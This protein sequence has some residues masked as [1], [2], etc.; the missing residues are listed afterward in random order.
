MMRK[1]LAALTAVMLVLPPAN[2]FA[3]ANGTMNLKIGQ[4]T[5]SSGAYVNDGVLYLELE[6]VCRALSY[7]VSNAGSDSDIRLTGPSDVIQIDPADNQVVQNGHTIGVAGLSQEDLLGGGCLRLSGTLYMRAD[8]L[9]QLLGLDVQ[10][11]E[12]AKTVTVL[13]II[14]NILSVQTR[15]SDLS[16][17]LLSATIQYPVLSGPWSGQ[18][19][20]AINTALKQA[21]DAALSQGRQNAQ[22]MQQTASLRKAS[23]LEDDGSLQC[24]AYFDYE[25]KYN[26]NGLFSIVLSNYQ[27]EGGA[28]GGTI[29]TA[30][31]FDLNTGKQLSLGSL[32]KNGSGYQ[33]EFDAKIRSGIDERE[34]SGALVEI[35]NSPFKTLGSNPD[36]YLSDA[37][38]AFYF[39]QYQYF[40]Y[41]AGIQEFT[42]PY[43]SISSMLNP[44]YHFLYEKLNRAA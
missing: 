6:P 10:T 15:R 25:V 35:A 41:A 44:S 1:L 22:E 11:D 20:N 8:L 14:Q 4:S 19:L 13:R 30:Y 43:G 34:K 24:A 26:Q 42:I 21:A 37:G 7:Q 3:A 38:I 2:C 18:S 12:T 39:Q 36:F 5:V 16:D 28:H 33:Q 23:G 40:P 17:G 9:S 31:T 32:M 29:Q 27:Y